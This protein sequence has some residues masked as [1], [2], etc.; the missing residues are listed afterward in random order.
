MAR[1]HLNSF[2]C[3]GRNSWKQ[4]DGSVVNVAKISGRFFSLWKAEFPWLSLKSLTVQ[5]IVSLHGLNFTLTTPIILEWIIPV[6]HDC[7]IHNEWTVH[8]HLT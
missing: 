6:T 3:K 4:L 1:K 2:L 7:P 8:L 5:H